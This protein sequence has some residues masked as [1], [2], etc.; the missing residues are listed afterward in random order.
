[1][2]RDIRWLWA[3]Y[4]VSTFGTWLGFGAFAL[5]AVLVLHAGPA[6]V[7]LLAAAGP[8]AGALVA[9]LL[10]PW[11]EAR[12]K[13]PVMVTMDLVRFAALASV[14]AAY[15]L[16]SLTLAH[17]VA[18]SI[19]TAAAGIASRAASG[20]F[21]KS[22]VPRD[23]LLA[24]NGRFEATT[25]TATL[26]GPPL[27]TAAIGLLGPVVTVAADAVSYLLSALGLRAI[28]FPEGTV[29]RRPAGSLLDGW[30]H[31]L[32]HRELRLLYANSVAVNGLIMATSPLVAVLLLDRLGFAPWQYGLAFGAP[33]LGG[34][35]GSRLAPPLVAR[36]GR[37]RVLRAAGVLRVCWPLGLAFPGPGTGG[38][39]LVLAVQFALVTCMGVYNP[40]LATHRLDRIAPDRVARALTA[41]S[42]SSN[43]GVAALTAVWGWLAGVAGLRTAIAAAGLLLLA[44]PL[45]LPRLRV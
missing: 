21:L 35:L 7:A 24:V 11:I 4:T 30:R 31:L 3:A 12:P 2:E 36:Y 22:L 42:V 27:G 19:V 45:L 1:M 8:A 39:V 44:T 41:W 9:V 13:R 34:L 18:V 14:P 23:V 28:R 5:I 29:D 26:V 32:R 38:L 6:G 20:A 43:A 16:G 40:V 25:W 10:G 15:A 33:C 17:L 37:H